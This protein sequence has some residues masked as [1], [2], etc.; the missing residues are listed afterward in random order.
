MLDSHPPQSPGRFVGLALIA[1]LLLIDS[2]FLILILLAPIGILTVL[3]G[4]LILGSLPLIGIVIYVTAGISSARYRVENGLLIIEWGRLVQAVPMREILE[5]LPSEE[6]EA[7]IEFRGVR[8]PG[9]MIG[10]G[11][12]RVADGRELRTAFYSTRT[13]ELQVLIVTDSMVYG[14]SPADPFAFIASLGALLESDLGGDEATAY[15]EMGILDWSVWPERRSLFLIGAAVALNLTLF[16]FLSVIYNQLPAEVPL[17][18]SQI[19]IVDRVGSPS[20]LFI[21]PLIGLIAWIAAV[22]LGWF[23]YF[24]RHEKPVAYIVW[25]ITVVI[26]LATWI[27]VVSLIK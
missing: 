23:F 27:A 13:L 5:I 2:G 9:C 14:L 19:G 21:L 22:I 3:L 26:E 15:S 6:I 8:W 12:L 11:L 4:L 10:Q 25:G 17:H 24:L 1:I 16:A 18:F 7:A 20:G